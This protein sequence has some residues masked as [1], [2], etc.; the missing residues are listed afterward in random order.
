MR[1]NIGR[2]FRAP[3]FSELYSN[4]VHGGIAAFQR[5]SADLSQETSLN[6]EAGADWTNGI[7]DPSATVYQNRFSNYIY[8]ANT[9]EIHGPSGL[10][11]YQYQQANARLRGVELGAQWQI[12]QQWSFKTSYDAVR[13]KF[14]ATSDRLPLLPA[15]SVTA[16][17][18]YQLAGLGT[19]E[20]PRIWGAVRHVRSRDAAG[21]YEPYSQFDNNSFGTAS[22]DAYTLFSMGGGVS[23]K[24]G[25]DLYFKADLRIENLLD[26]DYRDFLDT[27]KGYAMSQGRNAQLNMSI[28]F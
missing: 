8:L 25:N 4:G 14:T 12:N 20:K 11:I 15:D 16:R 6:I 2:G 17:V 9:N 22:T 26:E 27:Y 5:G 13:G 28:A 7:V 21:G 18:D 24:L 3:S 10:P 23:R 1:G 19:W